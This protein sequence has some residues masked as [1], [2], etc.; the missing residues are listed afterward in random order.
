VLQ[1]GIGFGLAVCQGGASDRA[2]ILGAPSGRKFIGI[3]A[4]D[5]TLPNVLPGTTDVYSNGDNM[6][7]LVRGDIWVIAMDAV[8]AGEAVY[9]NPVTGVLGSQS[10]SETVKC[11]N[12]MW[13]TSATPGSLPY[14][15]QVVPPNFAVCR[16]GTAT[17]NSE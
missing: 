2:A 9:F 10:S 7:V 13:M 1:T 12:A 14:G 17:G 8:T 11:E 16:L 4:A 6:A 5:I 3:T 15:N